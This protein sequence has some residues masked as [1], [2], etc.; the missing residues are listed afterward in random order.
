M[1]ILPWPSSRVIGSMVTLRLA[2]AYA[3]LARTFAS[4]NTC[5]TASY[6]GR[7]EVR[8]QMSEDGC[9]RKDDGKQRTRR[10]KEAGEKIACK[11]APTEE[12][13][14]VAGCG[15]PALHVIS[16]LDPPC[17]G[18]GFSRGRIGRRFRRDP[19]FPR[20]RG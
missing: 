18:G 11:Q 15:D 14:R 9:Q 5:L 10:R 7:G 6:M 2:A 16:R 17:D 13:V 19:E 3:A 20:A 12:E 1:S 4:L 8:S